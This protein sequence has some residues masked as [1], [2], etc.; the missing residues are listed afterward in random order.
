MSNNKKRF[1]ISVDAMGGDFAP[2]EIVSGAVQ[3]ARELDVEILLVGVKEDLDNE[4]VKHDISNLP[5]KL[6]E[7]TDRI[8]DGEQAAIAVMRKPNSSIALATRLVKDG[9]ADA[10]ISAGST[11]A[12]MVCALQ[13]LGSLPGI[14]RPMAGG[15]FLH[16]APD[17]VV[18]DLGANVGCQPYQYVNFAVAGSVYVKCFMGIEEPTIGLLNVGSEEGKGNSVSKE[19]YQLLQK[20]GLNFIGN[21]EGM[22]IPAGKANVIVCDGFIGNILLKFAEGIGYAV[23]QWLKKELANSIP[24]EIEKTTSKLRMMMSPATVLGGGPLWGVNGVV[25]V[26]HGN[27]QATHIV[28]T[29]KQTILALESGFI[30]KLRS[31]LENATAAI[32][33]KE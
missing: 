1:R 22:D 29:V 20:S 10:V 5:V 18:L 15:P 14:D 8:I 28:G 21:V 19:A 13:Y 26:A 11:G 7:A 17:T 12:V 30:D 31:E 32:N 9:E 3:A 33:D 4:I 23:S 25:S 16:F 6:I 24:D 27:S 2:G